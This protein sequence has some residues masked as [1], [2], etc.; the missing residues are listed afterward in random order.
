VGLEFSR[1]FFGFNWDWNLASVPIETENSVMFGFKPT[2]VA[3]V[4]EKTRH[5]FIV[6]SMHGRSIPI[7]TEKTSI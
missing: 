2:R 1:G 3:W 6:R 4:V 5:A 7:E